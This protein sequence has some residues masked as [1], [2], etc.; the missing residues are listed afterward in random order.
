MKKYQNSVSV[1][2]G[3]ASGIGKALCRELAQRGSLVIATDVNEDAL[4]QSIPEITA[5]GGRARA[6]ALNVTDHDAFD[7]LIADTARQEGRLDYLFNNA[8]IAAGGEI[9]DTSV[10]DWRKILDVNLFGVI[11]GSLS[12]YKL[13]TNQGFGHIINL[14][15][16]EGLVPFPSTASYV[17]SKFAVMGLSQSM[18]VE[19]RDLGVKVSVVCPGFIKTPIFDT[20]EKINLDPEKWKAAISA[21]E[22]FG[23]SPEKCAREIIKGV[24]KDKAIIPVTGMTRVMW[25]VARLS[26]TLMMKF[27]LKDYRR[28]RNGI[29][30]T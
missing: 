23:I 2:T 5:Q 7:K 15:S 9:R 19:G 28:W 22:R 3:A 13:M 14:S 30:L 12:A 1:V 18:W 25:W 8:G 16:V 26:P 20:S 6:A 21:Y 10:A 24:A 27:A 4:R 17:A 29:R 11:H